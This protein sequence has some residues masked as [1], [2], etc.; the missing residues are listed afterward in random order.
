MKR[1]LNPACMA[2][3]DKRSSQ[4]E[5]TSQSQVNKKNKNSISSEATT[6]IYLRERAALELTEGQV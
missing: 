2:A 5:M 1:A 6:T 4:S 3:A